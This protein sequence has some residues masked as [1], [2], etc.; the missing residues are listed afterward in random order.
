[1]EVQV[2]FLCPVHDQQFGSAGCT[3]L[4]LRTVFVNAGLSGTRQ[5]GNGTKKNADAGTS[6][7]QQ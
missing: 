5:S 1:M 4:H 3:P 2:V 6:P 7:V